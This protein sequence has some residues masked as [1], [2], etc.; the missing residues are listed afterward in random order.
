MMNSRSA[1]Q[2][3]NARRNCGARN[4]K[5]D[6]FAAEFGYE[7][8]FDAPLGL[9]SST[10]RQAHFEFVAAKPVLFCKRMR[11]ISALRCKAEPRSW[12]EPAEGNRRW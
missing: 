9:A 6:E 8:D 11:P 1:A 5:L 12:C 7:L 10:P 2:A 4:P 3:V